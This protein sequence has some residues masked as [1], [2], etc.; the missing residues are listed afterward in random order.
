MIDG[1]RPAPTILFDCYRFNYHV[2]WSFNVQPHFIVS[3]LHLI[4]L[5][6]DQFLIMEQL[7]ALTMSN[8][9]DGADSGPRLFTGRRQHDSIKLMCAQQVGADEDLFE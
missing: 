9:D 8:H 5:F 4:L 2:F 3:Q 1:L 7:W 6:L